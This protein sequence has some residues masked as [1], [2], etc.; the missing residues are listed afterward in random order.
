MSTGHSVLLLDDGELDDVRALLEELGADFVHL[1]G[2]AIPDQI[3]PPRDLFIATS[4]RAMAARHWNVGATG[5]PTKIGI[6]SEDSNTLRN[7]LRRIGFDLLV[8]RPTHPFALRLLLLRALYRGDERRREERR[9]IGC[10]VSYRMGLRRQTA[11]LADLSLRGCRLLSKRKLGVGTRITLQLPKELTGAKPLSLR[12]VVVRAIDAAEGASA[13]G[14][15]SYG[16]GF[17]K[18]SAAARSQVAG[19]LKAQ[20]GGPAVLSKESAQALGASLG[21]KVSSTPLAGPASEDNRRKHQRAS[22]E[23]EVVLLG[24]EA[25]RVL[26]GRDISVGGMQVDPQSGLAPGMEMDLAIYGAAREEPFIVHARV[27]RSADDSI[28]LEFD[29]L[30]PGVASRLEALVGSLPAVESLEDGEL[31][32]VGTVVSR[33]LEDPR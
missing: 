22:F 5:G 21:E 2:G 29:Q 32:S 10:E 6:V 27:V 28:A 7:M 19:I 26:V 17:D 33:I 3:E 14:E 9:A 31:D 20:A 4:R 11:I 12:S 16:V 23:R 25:S 30:A 8:R 1:R 13:N 24:D 18:P 15:Y